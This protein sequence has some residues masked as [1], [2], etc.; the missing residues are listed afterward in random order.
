M[1]TW[2]AETCRRCYCAY[3]IFSWN[4]VRVLPS[5]TLSKWFDFKITVIVFDRQ[6]YQADE[7]S[8]LRLVCWRQYCH[9]TK[10][11]VC[12]IAC[13]SSLPQ[14][15]AQCT[16]IWNWARDSETQLHA[17]V[18][19]TAKERGSILGSLAPE[20]CLDLVWSR[21]GPQLG[22][23]FRPSQLQCFVSNY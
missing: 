12:Q 4:C 14:A 16:S 11:L 3:N 10:H 23:A 19:R 17:S 2:V 15:S 7:S 1:A 18:C 5:V 6:E 20:G 22:F 13:V 8:S 21:Q 9:P